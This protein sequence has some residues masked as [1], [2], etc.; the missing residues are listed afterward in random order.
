VVFYLSDRIEQPVEEDSPA[1]DRW[2]FGIQKAGD[3]RH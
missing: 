3:R 2:E 1:V